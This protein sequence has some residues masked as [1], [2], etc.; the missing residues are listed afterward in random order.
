MKR[1]AP[2]LVSLAFFAGSH[3]AAAQSDL[4]PTTAADVPPA[5]GEPIYVTAG[6]AGA[7]PGGNYK[8]AL[9]AGKGKPTITWT[10]FQP[11]PD[12]S[13]RVFVQLTVPAT[14]E[15]N[16]GANKVSL[17]IHGS[18]IFLKNNRRPID[19]RFFNTPVNRITVKRKRHDAV[20]ELEM[21]SGVTPTAHTE[22]DP[23]GYTYLIFDFPPGD[24]GGAKAAPEPTA[25]APS[26]QAPAAPRDNLGEPDAERPPAV[27]GKAKANVKAGGSFSLGTR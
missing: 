5:Q 11:M 18:K 27:R 21:R 1:L 22:T 23:N 15:I 16:G 3:T 14:Y 7:E 6:Y 25:P 26:A 24:Y 4:D 20:I 8:P 17:V 12:G 9:P 2:Y 19:T 10:G 13:S